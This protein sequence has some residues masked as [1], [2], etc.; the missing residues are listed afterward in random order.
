MLLV[1]VDEPVAPGDGRAQGLLTTRVPG[2]R[3]AQD[4]VEVPEQ[5]GPMDVGAYEIQGQQK[6][7]CSGADTIFCNGFDAR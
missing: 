5:W 3:Q 6:I 7:T 4:L 1:G 2:Q